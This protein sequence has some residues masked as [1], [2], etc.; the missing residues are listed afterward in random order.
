MAL[1]CAFAPLEWWWMA[2]LAFLPMLALPTPHGRLERLGV[3]LLFGYS[4]FATS[5]HWLNTVGFGAGW[6]L[7]A[8][9][10]L[11]PAVWYY[12]YS[13]VLWSLKPREILSQDQGEAERAAA[14]KCGAGLWQ[15][16]R[17]RTGIAVAAVAAASWTALEWLRS[18]LFTGFPWNSLGISQAGTPFAVAARLFGI[19]GVSFIILFTNG[20]ILLA[21]EFLRR[22]RRFLPAAI[23]LT[24]LVMLIGT[25]LPAAFPAHFPPEHLKDTTLR[26]L[27]IQGDVP[28]CRV[29]NEQLFDMAWNRYADLTR[30]GFRACAETPPDLVLWPEGAL[31]A[32]ITYAPF[33]ARLRRLLAEIKTP[34]LLG[35]LDIRPI[36]GEPPENAPV[37]NTAFLLTADSPILASP[38]ANRGEYYDKIHRVPFG[39]YVPF[40]KYFPWLVDAIGM[41]RD[42]T[43][44]QYY[45]LFEIKGVKIG[46]N[47]CFEDAFPEIS[48][49]FAQDGANLLVTI[50][51]DCWY[52]KSA[53]AA[54]HRNHA[55]LR[56]VETGLPLLR[57]GNNSD[58]G[59]ISPDGGGDFREPILAPDGT[60]FGQGYHLYEFT[61]P[62]FRRETH[63]PGNTFAHLCAIA[64]ILTLAWLHWQRLRQ[65]AKFAKVMETAR[66]KK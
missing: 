2:W 43:A 53:G 33:A 47:I 19:C 21:G 41:G 12:L 11:Y 28:E 1:S 24:W 37:F 45:K 54:Q 7:A 57:S 55:I 20:L 10:A 46:V 35:A 34:I 3:G 26:I 14:L 44:G 50:T 9:C 16:A 65:H 36:P 58:T 17:Y 31:P 48:R 23:A 49:R 18:W 59:R 56:A 39:E 64:T 25:L 63:A 32:P 42:L 60:P 4:H 5:L 66:A 15:L 30:E 61:P 38:Y 51:N 27:A 52:L 8:Y 62:H 22:P 13:T 29:W 6:L 40:G